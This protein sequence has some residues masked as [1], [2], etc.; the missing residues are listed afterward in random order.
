MF[1][2]KSAEQK[3]DDEIRGLSD[4]CRI[5]WT[6]E[7]SKQ[8]N[9]QAGT[10]SAEKREENS[11]L[12]RRRKKPGVLRRARAEAEAS[13]IIVIEDTL[14][15][16]RVIVSPCEASNCSEKFWK[17]RPVPVTALET[18]TGEKKNFLRS[19]SVAVQMRGDDRRG[20][21]EERMGTSDNIQFG[22]TLGP[23]VAER[24]RQKEGD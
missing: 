15:V 5:C 8:A 24:R 21:G 10:L 3:I 9:R 20:D 22:S 12:I 6:G 13:R 18:G 4:K 14:C 7:V 19:A 1:P 11:R 16:R 17:K 23:G 2:G